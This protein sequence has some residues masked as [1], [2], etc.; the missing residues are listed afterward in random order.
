MR[1]PPVDRFFF[2]AD[3]GRMAV[4]RRDGGIYWADQHGSQQGILLWDDL[5]PASAWQI[6]RAGRPTVV[7]EFGRDHIQTNL[8][9]PV[10]EESIRPA[11]PF[12][13]WIYPGV[14]GF[15]SVRWHTFREELTQAPTTYN[16]ILPGGDQPRFDPQLQGNVVITI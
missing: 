13:A 3:I 9:E 8:L 6:A 7:V 4:A 5:D 15:E 10:R 12:R 16:I 1:R 11:R 2:T 14:I